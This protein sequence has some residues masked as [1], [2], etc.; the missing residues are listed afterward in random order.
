VTVVDVREAITEAQR[1]ERAGWSPIRMGEDSAA[2]ALRYQHSSRVAD[3]A[4]A[5]ALDARLSE[6]T[7]RPVPNVVAPWTVRPSRS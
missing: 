5:T 2:A 4:I 3:A 7:S 1:E 6:R